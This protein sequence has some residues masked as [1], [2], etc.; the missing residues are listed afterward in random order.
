MQAT[1]K[2][3]IRDLE[4]CIWVNIIRTI[5]GVSWGKVLYIFLTLVMIPFKLR[6]NFHSLSGVTTWKLLYFSISFNIEYLVVRY[7]LKEYVHFVSR[8]KR[9]M[10]KRSINQR[11]QRRTCMIII[12]VNV[13]VINFGERDPPVWGHRAW[14]EGEGGEA[15]G[16]QWE[17]NKGFWDTT[18]EIMGDVMQRLV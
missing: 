9:L 11:R 4:A 3:E 7:R 8:H 18:Y 13:K 15:E 2:E 5:A 16:E 10:R 12:I 1:K 6:I 14:D 17:E